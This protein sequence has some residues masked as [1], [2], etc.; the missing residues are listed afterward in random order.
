DPAVASLSS[1]IGVDGS[2]PT[3]NTGRLL[4]NLKPHSERDVTAR[5][6]IQRLQPELDHLPGIKLYM[7]P[8]QDLTI[9][10]RI[11]RTQYQFTLQDADPDVLAE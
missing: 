2:N 9:E 3:L 6:V 7:Q 5:E 10:D 8:V 4:I 11:A 1:Y